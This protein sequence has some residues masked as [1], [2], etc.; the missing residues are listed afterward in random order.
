MSEPDP[1]SRLKVAEICPNCF[2]FEERNSLRCP[3]CGTFH[4]SNIL[5][6]EPPPESQPAPK[7]EVDSR[8]Y[9]LDPTFSI[10]DEFE[11]EIED[12]TTQ[13]RGG[14]TSFMFSSEE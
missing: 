2:A 6:E 3:E 4:S 7:R 13:W 9:S 12:M 1:L 8:F 10:P 11:E 14:G 5:N